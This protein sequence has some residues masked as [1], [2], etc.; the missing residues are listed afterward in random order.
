LCSL[1]R[2]FCTSLSISLYLHK[3]SS[4][5]PLANRKLECSCSN[6]RE[7]L[8]LNATSDL[9]PLQKVKSFLPQLCKYLTLPSPKNQ[10]SKH[11]HQ[12]RNS[13]QHCKRNPAHNQHQSRIKIFIHRGY[14]LHQRLRKVN[15]FSS[16]V[17]YFSSSSSSSSIISWATS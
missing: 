15:S 2:I 4:Y 10:L 8:L 14:I 6:V 3:A 12:I 13:D 17:Y 5:V 9:H 16:W 7:P 11:A 1:Y